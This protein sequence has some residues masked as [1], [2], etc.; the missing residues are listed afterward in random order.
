MY[1]CCCKRTIFF[2]VLPAWVVDCTEA[3]QI[4]TQRYDTIKQVLACRETIGLSRTYVSDLESVWRFRSTS[5][6]K[7]VAAN[8]PSRSFSQLPAMAVSLLYSNFKYFS[9]SGRW[10]LDLF[11]PERASNFS[12]PGEIRPTLSGNARNFAVNLFWRLWLC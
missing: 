11:H 6:N 3:V 10:P 4:T 9:I 1:I 2:C 12:I 8:V 5:C 7:V